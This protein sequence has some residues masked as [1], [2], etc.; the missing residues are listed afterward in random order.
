M[1]RRTG[2]TSRKA[3]SR[4]FS[5]FGWLG[6]C[7]CKSQTRWSLLRGFPSGRVGDWK[8][9]RQFEDVKLRGTIQWWMFF[10][11]HKSKFWKYGYDVH[12]QVLGC[13]NFPTKIQLGWSSTPSAFHPSVPGQCPG[14]APRRPDLQNLKERRENSWQ[15]TPLFCWGVLGGSHP[16]YSKRLVIYG[17]FEPFETKII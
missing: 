6:V 8:Y 10:F 16:T 5:I 11:V 7:L 9:C 2:G 4:S 1:Q 13:Q 17:G 14:T 3:D 12:L 15:K